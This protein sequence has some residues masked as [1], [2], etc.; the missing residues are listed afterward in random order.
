MVKVLLESGHDVRGLIRES[1]NTVNL[2]GLEV[3]TVIGDI[4]KPKEL[5]EAVSGVDGVFHTAAL[6]S[7]WAPDYEIFYETNVDGTENVLRAAEEAGVERLV[8]TSTASLLAHSDDKRSLPDSPDDLPSDYKISKY[9]AERTA[10]DFGSESAMDVLVASPTVPIGPGDYGPTPTGR[11]ILEFLNGRMKGFVDMDFNLVDVED[12]AEGHLIVME[13]GEPGERYVLG[14]RN[15]SL[16]EV[17]DLLAQFTGLPK[18]LFRI[19]YPL[20]LGAAWVDEFLEGFLLNSRP[21][22]PISAIEST[23]VDER[24]DPTPW[25]E[26]LG[27]P[28][29]PLA[30]ALKKSIDWFVRN[31]YVKNEGALRR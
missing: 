28:K 12:V 30:T 15:T 8:F 17:I 31:G 27:L 4:R 24:I 23:R 26:D 3:E 5:E 13:D 22:I 6:Y 18:P 20:A 9:F 1:S 10:L 14:N 11:L 16:S 2:E 25:V 19:P 21:S 29:T 7:F